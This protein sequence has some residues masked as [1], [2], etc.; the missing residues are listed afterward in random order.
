M[1]DVIRTDSFLFPNTK[2]PVRFVFD[3]VSEVLW[4]EVCDSIVHPYSQDR[5][6]SVQDFCKQWGQK[7]C[8][9]Q[10]EANRIIQKEFPQAFSAGAVFLG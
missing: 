5:E 7:T 4:M 8:A 10:L 6:T 2:T 9:S 1:L 3:S